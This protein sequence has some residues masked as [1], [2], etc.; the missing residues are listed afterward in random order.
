M[1]Y[2]QKK[3]GVLFNSGTSSIHILLAQFLKSKKNEVILSGYSC[4]DIVDAI[5]LAGGKAI[6]ID[7]SFRQHIDVDDIKKKITDKTAAIIIQ[8][9]FGKTEKINGIENMSIPIIEDCTHSGKA[10]YNNSYVV[11]SFG[12]TKLLTAAEGGGVFL[13]DK[14]TYKKLRNSLY[15]YNHYPYR[16]S[17]I[18]SAILLS[19]ITNFKKMIKKRFEIAKKYN[20]AFQKSNDFI[21]P[22]LN[23]YSV[24]YR[25][26]LIFKCPNEARNYIK[27][28]K[29]YN[30]VC[31]TP[32]TPSPE[33][34]KIESTYN[35]FETI[36]SL[37]IYPS[38]KNWDVKRIIKKHLIIRR[39][40]NEL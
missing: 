38:L 1:C 39:I 14:K 4:S 10:V 19:Q 29:K 18:N 16:E 35:D 40:K 27:Y 31:A 32:I 22:V 5:R 15:G 24:I 3:Y 25:Y 28:M 17:D 8:H 13:N 26:V 37:P 23:E 2:L 33:A 9:T 7:S 36:V 11:S 34:L 12:A 30:I 6:F 21:I 20:K